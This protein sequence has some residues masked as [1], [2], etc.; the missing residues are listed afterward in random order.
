MTQVFPLSSFPIPFSLRLPLVRATDK[1]NGDQ[2]EGGPTIIL[3]HMYTVGLDVDTRA[4]FTAATM[5]IAVP[6]GIK[7]FSWLATI[8]GGS[9]RFFTP[10]LFAV[11]FL[12][13]FTV[14]GL[15]G[16]ILANAAL[17]LALHDTYYVVAHFH[18]V[19]SM[20]AVFALFAAFYY[21]IGKI[22]GHTYNELLGQIHFYTMFIGVNLTFFPMHMLGLAGK[23]YIKYFNEAD[24]IPNISGNRPGGSPEWLYSMAGLCLPFILGV[25]DYIPPEGG[26]G[27]SG[28]L[29]PILIDLGTQSGNNPFYPPP[30]L[31]GPSLA[32]IPVSIAPALKGS[33]PWKGL[34]RRQGGEAFN[35]CPPPYGPHIKPRWLNAIPPVRVYDNLN[36][37]RNLIG[38]DNRKRSIIY[39]W[40]N[41]ITGKIYIGSAWNGSTRLLSYWTPSTLRRNYPIYHNINYYGISNFSLAIIEDLGISGSVTKE[42]ILSREQHYLDILFTNYPRQVINLSRIAGSTKGYKH[43]SKF[44]LSRAGALNPM[45]G[46][47]K[48][49]EFIDMQ[50]RDKSGSKN[51]FYGKYKTP[52]TIAKIT[53]LVYVY[54]YGRGYLPNRDMATAFLGEFSTVRCSKHYNMGKDTLTKYIKNG[55]PFKGK[56]FSH[57]KLH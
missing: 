44:G 9:V 43:Q 4:Y 13:L 45:Y 16:I 40:V 54:D 15:T 3:H 34:K 20:G 19:L 6:T 7:I 30:I 1:V 2:K 17:D 28:G 26:G 29:P 25:G 10:M 22:T 27:P 5:I 35:Y 42:F 12:F 53:K 8:Y 11:G 21:W 57:E 31:F 32:L 14:G 41:L 23:Q 49:K 38:S 39:Q 46:R 33:P 18:Y 48:S 51:P 55:L 24:L 56:I 36:F 47:V 50:T 37:H 52:S